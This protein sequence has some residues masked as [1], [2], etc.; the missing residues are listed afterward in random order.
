MLEALCLR[1][2]TIFNPADETDLIHGYSM[3]Y[4]RLCGGLG[5]ILGEWKL[6]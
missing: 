2:G 6:K 5:Y 3:S 4:D 1:C